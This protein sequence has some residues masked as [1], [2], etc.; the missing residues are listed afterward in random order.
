MGVCSLQTSALGCRS[1]IA[2]DWTAGVLTLENTVKMNSMGVLHR[3]FKHV[4][5]DHLRVIKIKGSGSVSD[6]IKEVEKAHNY[7]F[8][9]LIEE[10]KR[11]DLKWKLIS[12]I[13]MSLESGA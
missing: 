10:N 13:H 5:Q 7:M 9:A 1:N 6:K 8:S 2:E 4:V 11:F 3:G 12:N